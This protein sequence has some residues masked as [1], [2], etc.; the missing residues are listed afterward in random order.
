MTGQVESSRLNHAC[1]K[2][3]GGKR[4][5]RVGAL[6]SMYHNLCSVILPKFSS[7][8]LRGGL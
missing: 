5:E 7:C 6:I 3:T 4:E 8:G 1:G 2:R